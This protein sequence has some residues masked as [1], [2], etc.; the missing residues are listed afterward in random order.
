MLSNERTPLV[1]RMHELHALTDALDAAKRGSGSI[2]MVAGEGGV[3]KTRLVEAV[4]EHAMERGFTVLVGRA[5]PVETGIPYAIFGDGFVPYLRDLGMPALQTLSR[6]AGAELA[7]LFPLLRTD[8]TAVRA[9]DPAELKPRLFDAFGQLLGALA[10]KA[11]MLVVL[12]NLHWADPSSIDLLHFVARSASAHPLLLLATYNDAH[13]ESQR[14][15]R[16]LEQSLTSLGVLSRHVLPPLTRDE[17]AQL[18]A[19]G[20]GEQGA[21]LGDFPDRVHA[22]TRG[23]P[24][25]IEETL[26]ALVTAGRLRREGER[27]VGWATEQLSLPDSIRDALQLRYDRLSAPAQEVVQ[28]AAVVGAQVPHALLERLT[29]LDEATLLAAV[30]ELRRGRVFDEIDGAVGPA[31]VFTHPLLQE[32]LYA[33]LGRVRVRALHGRIADALERAYGPAA[34][35][36]AEEIAIHF[37]RA[38]APEQSARA[39][40]YLIAAGEIAVARGSH[41]EAAES[42]TVALRLVEASGDAAALET[43]LESLGRAKHRLGDYAAATSLFK[44]AVTLAEARGD[45]RR[46]AALERRVGLA[47]LR[48]GEFLIALSHHDRGLAAALRAGDRAAEATFHLARSAGMMEVGDGAAAEEAGRMALAIAEPLGDARLLGRVHQALQALN[49]WRG[50]SAAAVLHGTR[51]IEH[52]RRADDL[53]T[54]WQA[55]WV[56]SVH[57]GLTGDS[58]ATL[59]HVTQASQL[60]DQLRS[61]V[62][63]LWSAEVAI[64]YRSGIGEWDE[65]LALAERTIEEARAFSQNNLLPR[66]LVWSGLML[67]GRGELARAKERLDEAWVRSG[68]DRADEGLPLNVHQVVPAHVGIGYYHLYRRDHRTALEVAERGLAIADR[69]GYTV[70][71]VHR[72]LPL[73]AEASLWLR[74]WESADAYGRRLRAAAEQLGH[75]LAHAWADACLALQRMLQGDHA[76]AIA[77]LRQ[78]ADALETIPFVEHAARLRRKLAEALIT[79]GDLPAA[80]AEL[81]RC[82]EVFRRIG[83]DLA[84]DEVREQMREHGWR[85]RQ[86]RLPHHGRLTATEMKVASLAA[87]GMTNPQIGE[88]L[89]IS[90]RTAST[91]ISNIFQK[92]EVKSRHELTE[93]LREHGLG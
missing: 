56:F 28:L 82:H 73:A 49:V 40:T 35:Q 12:E 24:F 76:G 89:R 41:R 81:E 30:D 92:L 91:H 46:V 20:F 55:E 23:N 16:L 45:D 84:L 50:P 66:L 47:W 87:R 27:W 90:P 38:E 37:R 62:L 68:A 75:P 69:T 61:P 88:A 26:K 67:C 51:A 80:R 22:R 52:A 48:R 19:K 36:H 2:R 70:W 72:L 13:R 33:E 86:T 42:L 21:T 71:A 54:A 85:P 32:M 8:T 1:G 39:V 57:A 83:A 4:R 44:R 25:F 77:Q 31:Y 10:R 53:R 64:E 34:L 17:T 5:F 63:R 18:I 43:V 15:L 6:G 29:E 74:E 93:Y 58:A 59:R 3:G 60:A 79:A 7:L 9:G 11:P 78:A 65:A 14:A